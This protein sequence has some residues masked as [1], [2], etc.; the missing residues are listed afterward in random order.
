MT[1]AEQQLLDIDAHVEVLQFKGNHDYLASI[2]N[3]WQV[4]PLLVQECRLARK[5]AEPGTDVYKNEF[6]IDAE[7][8]YVISGEC[9]PNDLSE[10]GTVQ[11]PALVDL[12]VQNLLNSDEG[13]EHYGSGEHHGFTWSIWSHVSLRPS[14]ILL[15]RDHTGKENAV[16][17][18]SV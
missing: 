18:T 3:H 1:I 6:Y 2:D 17:I 11:N 7:K 5:L 14:G 13:W 15:A 8:S 16:L 9:S 10:D 12:W 4:D